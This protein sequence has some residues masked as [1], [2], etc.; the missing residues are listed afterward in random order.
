[1]SEKMQKGLGKLLKLSCLSLIFVSTV[2]ATEV[3]LRCY[4]DCYY[5]EK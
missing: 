4:T 2:T 1:M 5:T 3:W